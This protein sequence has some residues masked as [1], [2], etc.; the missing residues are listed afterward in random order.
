MNLQYQRLQEMCDSLKLISVAQG[1]SDLAQDAVKN[2]VSY[3]DF[4]EKL[5]EA[6]I[7]ERQRRSQRILTKIAGFPAIKTLDD[8]D[9]S[10]AGSIKKQ[11]LKN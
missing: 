9:Y 2:Q 8:F 3:T 11:P 7:K 10:F 4:L 1:Y 6:E 5:L